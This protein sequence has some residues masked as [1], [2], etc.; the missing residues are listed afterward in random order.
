MRYSND[1][2]TIILLLSFC[3][4]HEIFFICYCYAVPRII[5]SYYSQTDMQFK[6]PHI[7]CMN[8]QCGIKT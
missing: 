4:M 6:N 1:H 3:W 7:L 8:L 2:F 5:Y